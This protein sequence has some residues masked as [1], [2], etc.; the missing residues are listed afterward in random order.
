MHDEIRSSIGFSK[1][2]L[3]NN[4]HLIDDT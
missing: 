2:N 1:L 3:D 4:K